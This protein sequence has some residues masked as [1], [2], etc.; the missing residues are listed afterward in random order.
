M[1]E[2][3]QYRDWD[4]AYVLGA[5]TAD[6]RRAFERHM[7]TCAVCRAE[8]GE[9]AG[10]PG[11]LAR[12]DAS[13]AV[14][15]DAPLQPVADGTRSLQHV[16]RRVRVRRRRR[17]IV[18]IAAAGLAVVAAVLGGVAVG[19]ARVEP[20][21]SAQQGTAPGASRYV[22]QG[23]GG[24][25]SLRVDLAVTG[26]AWGTRFDWGCS[27]E[28]GSWDDEA[29]TQYDMVVLRDDG[30]PVTVATWSAAGADAKDLAAATD[31]QLAS[32][33][34]VEVRVHGSGTVLASTSL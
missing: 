28:G 25:E 16:A 26:K 20:T 14:A 13:D 12:L 4:A 5:L 3:D 32:I 1:N 6:D 11:V 2:H 31:V 10:M 33:T 34:S 22:M 17:R 19:T 9:L 27:Y 30:A 24:E 21:V 18:V 29:G 15:L 23:S 8:V 7:E